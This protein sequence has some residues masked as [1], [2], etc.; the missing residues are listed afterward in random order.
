MDESDYE[1]NRKDKSLRKNVK[2]EDLVLPVLNS[3]KNTNQGIYETHEPQ[4]KNNKF[5]TVQ[6]TKRSQ[7]SLK[8][9]SPH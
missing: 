8:S 1:D 6:N 7:K 4:I 5:T 2:K 9:S 3:G